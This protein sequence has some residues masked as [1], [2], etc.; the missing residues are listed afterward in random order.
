MADDAAR[1]LFHPF[2]T[3]LLPMPAAGARILVI[4]PG[5]D[6][7]PPRG[8]DADLVLV[9]GFRPSYNALAARGF[10]VLPEPDRRERFDAA[11]I[12]LGRHRGENDERL[13]RAALAVRPGGLV[14]VAGAKTNGADS[15]RKRLAAAF[16]GLGHAAKHHGLA[17][18]F[19]RPDDRAVDT[20]LT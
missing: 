6:F 8:F 18:W 9:Q 13:H 14:V 16:P 20:L 3:G 1:T 7:S 5:P 12:L 17:L 11:L 19:D 2:E 4:G 15:L 10:T